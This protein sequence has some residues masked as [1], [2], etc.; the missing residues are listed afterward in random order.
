MTPS[1]PHFAP[2][3]RSVRTLL[4]AFAAL[5]VWLVAWPASAAAPICDYRGASAFAPS[6]TLDP[7]DASIDIGMTPDAC[8][9]GVERDASYHQGRVPD[10]LPSP[11]FASVLPLDVRVRVLSSGAS[12]GEESFELSV[13]RLGVRDRLERPPRD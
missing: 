13:A 1:D 2:M 6:P 10:P 11:T 3:P 12:R 7:Q 8:P 5:A 4:V 9:D